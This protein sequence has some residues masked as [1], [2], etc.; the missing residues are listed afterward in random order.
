VVQTFL[1]FTI[2]RNDARSAVKKE[3][4]SRIRNDIK[5]DRAK[6]SNGRILSRILN[7]KASLIGAQRGRNYGTGL[8]KS[9]NY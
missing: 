4:S 1:I 9:A 7:P 6:S 5:R 8:I 2:I 3:N